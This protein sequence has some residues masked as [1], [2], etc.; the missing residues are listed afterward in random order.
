MKTDRRVRYTRMMLKQALLSL[1]LERPINRITVTEICA[2]AEVNRATFYAHYKDPYDLLARIENELFEA[3]Q[4]SI[5]RGLS[6]SSLKEIL[7]EICKS[8]QENGD[9]CRV[10]FSE[11]GDREFLSRVLNIPHAESMAFWQKMAP[12]AEPR[13]LARLYEFF[14]HGSAGV[15]RSW[16]LSGMQDTPE[17][18]AAFIERISAGGFAQVAGK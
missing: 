15:I 4:A 16:V 10:I 12:Q 13:A 2:Q 17:E 11:H 14:S 18:I 1:M 7:T 6:K 3:I 5:R 8:I 9:L